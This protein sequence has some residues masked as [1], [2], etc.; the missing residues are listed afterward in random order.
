MDINQKIKQDIINR[1]K[2]A[3]KNRIKPVYIMSQPGLS[4]LEKDAVLDGVSEIIDMAKIKGI[5]IKDFGTWRSPDYLSKNGILKEYNSVDWYIQKGKE[6]S[7]NDYQINAREILDLLSNEPWKKHQ[8]HYDVIIAKEDIYQVNL[9]FIIG[10]AKPRGDTIISTFRFNELDD[11]MK[12]EC[13][14][15]EAMHEICHVFGMISEG[16]TENVEYS[17]G[18][19][20]TNICIM[21]QGVNVPTDWINIT[22]DRLKYNALCN[23]CKTEL[24][25]Y[26]K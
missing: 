13:I 24:I 4:N 15:T 21:R 2:S 25:N 26:F 6:T 10:C 3:K 12:Y 8:D 22:N 20:C 9:N 18:K 23:Q 5:I 11:R 19:H 7:R 17:L 1:V 16:R 14:K